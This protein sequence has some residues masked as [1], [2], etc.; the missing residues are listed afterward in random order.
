LQGFR[1][2]RQRC[3]Q[4]LLNLS[5]YESK[6]LGFKFSNHADNDYLEFFL[7]AGIIGCLPLA[8]L[9]LV[10]LLRAVG[11]MRHRH[12]SHLR[13]LAYGSFMGMLAILIHS[14]VDFNLQI[15]P[16]AALFV[17]LLALAW[18]AHGLPGRTLGS[19]APA[20]SP[21]GHALK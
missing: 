19:N 7:E 18:V 13:A 16:N 5:R 8:A 14:N 3:R 10:S 4:L 21:L 12:H 20:P 6:E 17:V 1:S 11:A 9:V 2:I 15:S